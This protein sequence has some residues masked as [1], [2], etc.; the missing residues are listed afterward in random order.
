MLKGFGNGLKCIG[1]SISTFL[2][3]K[4]NFRRFVNIVFKLNALLAV[5]DKSMQ[6]KIFFLLAVVLLTDTLF[7]FRMKKSLHS[8]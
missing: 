7:G 4:F 3:L 5:W 6:T 8:S 1:H 2:F